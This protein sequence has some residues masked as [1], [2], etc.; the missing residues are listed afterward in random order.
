MTIILKFVHYH[1]ILVDLNGI[2]LHQPKPELSVD[3]SELKKAAAPPGLVQLHTER[4]TCPTQRYNFYD[5]PDSQPV[6]G[7][8]HP[9]SRKRKFMGSKNVKSSCPLQNISQMAMH[10]FCLYDVR[11]RGHIGKAI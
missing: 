11:D 6:V 10:C 9:H 2:T 4:K 3:L 7:H 5:L 8:Q 1:L